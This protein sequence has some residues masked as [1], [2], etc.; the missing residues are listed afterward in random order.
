[1]ATL[2][3]LNVKTG[4]KP[5]GLEAR[6]WPKVRRTMDPDACWEWQGYRNPRGYGTI[7]AGSRDESMLLA[8]RVAYEIANGAIPLDKPH[9]CHHCDNPPCCNPRHL[10]AGTRSDNMRDCVSK[11]RHVGAVCPERLARG[12]RNGSRRHPEKRLRGEQHPM[13]RLCE[14]DV[15]A[16]RSRS[17]QSVSALAREFDVGRTTVQRVLDRDTWRHVP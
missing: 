15:L 4:P 16:I 7:G 8:H 2:A 9:I 6:F 13:S 17:G 3:N 10:F 12:D 11:R 5:K 1:M 14:A